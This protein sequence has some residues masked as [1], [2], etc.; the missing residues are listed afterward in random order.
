MARERT[1]G[2]VNRKGVLFARVSYVDEFGKRREVTRRARD[3]AHA[4]QIIAELH[5]RLD[6]HGADAVRKDSLPLSAIIEEYRQ[7]KAQPAEMRDGVKIAGMKSSYNFGKMLDV[8]AEHLG[9]KT[10]RDLKPGDLH[11]FK[12]KRLSTPTQYG[13]ARTV[14]SVNRE[15]E[16]LR[17]VCRWCVKQGWISRSPFEYGEAVILKT[18]EASRDRVLSHAEE[19]RLLDACTG[20]RARLRAVV[21]MAVDSAMRKGE[22]LKLCWPMVNLAQGVISL[23]GSI[24]KTGKLRQVPITPRLRAE[25]EALRGQGSG[26]SQAL[27]F[28]GL[29]VKYG[30]QAACKA[31]NVTGVRFHDLRHTA[32]TRMVAAGVNT[33][34]VMAISGHDSHHTFLKYLNPENSTLREVAGKLHDLNISEWGKEGEYVN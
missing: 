4:K 17:C 13:K 11:R 26:D 34:L 31:A 30:W 18:H 10:L 28:G 3:K 21:V 22:I 12:Q 15:L 9:H 27:V 8:L 32:I 20:K 19:E 7:E 24:T 16:A 25:L 2:I 29:D 6:R 23:P 1:G 33:A 5:E 14:A